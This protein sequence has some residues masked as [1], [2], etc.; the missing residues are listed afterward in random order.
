VTLA[1]HPDY[2]HRMAIIESDDTTHLMRQ[3]SKT[4]EEYLR[5]AVAA[6]DREFGDGFAKKTPELVAAV[7][8]A[9]AQ[10]FHTTQMVKVIE[11]SAEQLSC[12]IDDAAIRLS[13]ALKPDDD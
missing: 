13:E 7:V 2:H 6:I 4:A 3:A 9:A 10:G 11:Q 5:E 8:T 1:A 12:S